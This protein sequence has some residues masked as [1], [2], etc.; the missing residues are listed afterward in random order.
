M[1]PIDVALWENRAK[2]PGA[3]ETEFRG[4]KGEWLLKW[5]PARAHDNG[6]YLI[7]SNGGS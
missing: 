4:R 1:G 5:P 3:I 7:F 6:I 2:D